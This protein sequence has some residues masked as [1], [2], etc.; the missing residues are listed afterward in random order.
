[1]AG[2]TAAHELVERGFQVTL[3]E[4]RPRVE[5]G[6][7]SRSYDR[8]PRARD[9]NGH[10]GR[11]YPAE[12]GFRFL[13]GFYRHLD[14][15]MAR[16][17]LDPE[18]SRAPN[19]LSNLRHIDE[20]LL[21]VTGK[22][23]I[24]IPAAPPSRPDLTRD[25]QRLLRFPKSL[26]DVGLTREDLGLFAERLWQIAT[27]SAERR[28]QEYER[29]GWRE[30]VGSLNRSDEYY[31][32]LASG[33]TRTLIAA[34]AS[35]TSTKT[36][37]N[38]ALQLL[39]CFSERGLTSDRVFNGPTNKVWIEP[40][41]RQIE[42]LAQERG[43]QF[44]L[45][46]SRRVRHLELSGARVSR[47]DIEHLAWSAGGPRV[48]D[49]ESLE[50]FDH[51][52]CALSPDAVAGLTTHQMLEAEPR[53]TNLTKLVD[54]KKN[55][56]EWM[57]GL[58]IY[59]KN[60]EVISPGHQIFLDSPWG[61]TSIS[62]R[63]FWQDAQG[64]SDHLPPGQGALSIDISSWDLPGVRTNRCAK[65]IPPLEIF[66]EVLVQIR[67]ALGNDV[68]KDENILGF[69]LDEAVGT[70]GSSVNLEPVLV[71]HVNTFALRPTAT[72]SIKNLFLAGDY[73]QTKTDLACMESANEAAR[74]A[75][76][77][78]LEATG[79][80]GRCRMFDPIE[81]EPGWL[82]P[83]QDMDAI[84]YRR[85]LP[86]GGVRLGGAAVEASFAGSLATDLALGDHERGPIRDAGPVPHLP[87]PSNDPLALPQPVHR[88]RWFWD[89]HYRAEEE[90]RNRAR[91]GKTAADRV[92][93]AAEEAR[94]LSERQVQ[95][96]VPR[97]FAEPGRADLMF[98]RWRLSRLGLDGQDYLIPFQA[99]D[100]DAMVIHGHACN[101]DWLAEETART[102]WAP[103]FWKNG[104]QKVGFAEL[105][106]MHYRDTLAAP[107]SEV[108]INFVVSPE[109]MAGQGGR[110]YRWRTPYSSLVPMM[111]S[112]NRLFTPLLLLQESDDKKAKPP[113]GPIAY[114]NRLFGLNKQAGT[115]RIWRQGHSKG[116]AVVHEGQDVLWGAID[117]SASIFQD[118]ADA[119]GLARE[120]GSLEML[121][122]TRQALQG[123]ELGGGL[124][125][126]DHR[127]TDPE[128]GDRPTVE[129]K[130]AYKFVP[131]LRLLR[132]GD[133]AN[134]VRWDTQSSSPLV[135]ILEKMQFKPVIAA[136]D[137]RLKAVLYLDGWPTPDREPREDQPDER[138][139]EASAAE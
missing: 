93:H 50:G 89:P 109:E 119:A 25:W 66:Q 117:E 15:T 52:V 67:N 36:M 27:S 51:V 71:N 39:V 56:L 108:V 125:T 111:D 86:W 85:G 94:P 91:M 70:S 83:F 99:Y 62:Q 32:Y 84:R 31:W 8:D 47:I 64:H 7:R 9:G 101:F 48:I 135:D 59:L 28:N 65:E 34:K 24:P 130:A 42:A 45:L 5:L 57:N 4:R 23:H 136:R 30:F 40:W 6:G 116:F 55:R 46:P 134:R 105:W 129:I 43:T 102:G 138:Q 107:Y 53:F 68:L 121:R 98:R 127:E 77:G 18:S 37:G 133:P 63:Q 112:T 120:I 88:D 17:S 114:G 22:V 35:K 13:P 75:V 128:A 10:L 78:I 3:V 74:A 14:D 33:L 76:N 29:I 124:V 2:L 72:T 95:Q 49:R 41:L 12:H 139:P 16:I 20:E 115:I 80:P 104:A 54:P 73:V 69:Y 137:P 38:I 90:T 106:V 118:A 96:W 113:V 92:R 110:E 26:L 1:M 122:N 100:C 21:A 87:S 61:L 132:E 131:K 97:T 126:R 81:H 19:V 60:D 79:H 11:L 44:H 58:Q 123:E 103:A 82:K